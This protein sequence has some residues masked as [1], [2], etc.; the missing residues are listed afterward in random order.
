LQ[1]NKH[2]NPTNMQLDK[3][4]KLLQAKTPVMTRFRFSVQGRSSSLY[5]Q[6]RGAVWELGGTVCAVGGGS[7]SIR[8]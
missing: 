5:G 2:T 8:V 4:L 6:R 7:D 1:L 3:V